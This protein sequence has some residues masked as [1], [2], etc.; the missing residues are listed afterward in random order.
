MWL[1]PDE[2][3]HQVRWAVGG[4]VFPAPRVLP[5]E[6]PGQDQDKEDQEDHSQ[7]S[8]REVPPGAT[9]PPGRERPDKEQDQ[10]DEQNR[11]HDS[12]LPPGGGPR[13][14]TGF[15]IAPS[16]FYALAATII[17]KPARRMTVSK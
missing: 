7:P 2:P 14:D 6:A 15:A 4:V 9:V 5:S 1:G 17:S 10:H 3:A 12:L 11:S 13:K 16:S 8:A